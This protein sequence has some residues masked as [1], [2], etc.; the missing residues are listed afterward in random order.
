MNILFE[1]NNTS[2]LRNVNLC[3]CIDWRLNCEDFAHQGVT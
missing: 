3:F 2:Q 1:V